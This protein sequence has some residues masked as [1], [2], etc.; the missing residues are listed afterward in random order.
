MMN[1]LR[2]CLSLLWVLFA[3][4]VFVPSATWGYDAQTRQ[5][6]GYHGVSFSACNY[7]TAIILAANEEANGFVGT[8]GVFA[9]LAEFQAAGNTVTRYVGATEARIAQETGFIP[10]VDRFGQPKVVYVT[11]EAPVV[12]ASQAESIYQIGRANP[13]GATAPPTHVIVGNPQG[14]NFINGG[15]VAGSTQLGTELLTTER[16]PVI[17]V[18][19]IGGN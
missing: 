16:I 3:G 11:P 4:S 18:R 2:Y 14:I 15:N 5:G 9:N 19:P 7:D 17:S 6:I 13:M 12:S 10:N 8:G 1:F